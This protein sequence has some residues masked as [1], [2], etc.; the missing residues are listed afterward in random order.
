MVIDTSTIPRFT[1]GNNCYTVHIPSCYNKVRHICVCIFTGFHRGQKH[2]SCL[3]TLMPGTQHKLS[4][5]RLK[6][7]HFL[8]CEP[9]R[10]RGCVIYH[11]IPSVQCCACLR[12][13][14]SANG[15][16]RSFS[17]NR[18]LSCLTACAFPFLCSFQL[19]IYIVHGCWR[20]SPE[21]SA[22]WTDGH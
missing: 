20:L 15:Q 2:S 9:L 22:F 6:W 13:V 14:C 5:Q 11:Q 16:E 12:E 18:K 17:G 1:D 4:G 8:D 3:Q 10:A 21:A 19:I 7:G